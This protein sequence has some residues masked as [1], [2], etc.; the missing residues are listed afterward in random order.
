MALFNTAE[1]DERRRQQSLK[2]KQLLEEL[3]QQMEKDLK[4]IG[5]TLL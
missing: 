1:S 3:R 5:S 4:V 2:K